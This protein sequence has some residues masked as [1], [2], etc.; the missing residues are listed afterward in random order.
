MVILTKYNPET[1]ALST[2]PKDIRI[3]TETCD[4]ISVQTEIQTYEIQ[5]GNSNYP[6][7]IYET[8]VVHNVGVRFTTINSATLAFLQ[9]AE[10][11][12]ESGLMK[13][14]TQ[15]SI[16]T[17]APYEIPAL[18]NVSGDGVVIDSESKRFTKVSSNPGINQYSITP[19]T[20]GTR[21]SMAK[22]V[23]AAATTAGTATI[24][25]TAAGS[26]A[27][28][29]GKAVVVNL[30]DTSINANASEIRSALESD[31]DISGYFD[32][33]GEDSEVILTRKVAADAESEAFSFALGTAEGATMGATTTI[34][35]EPDVPSKFVFN[36]ANKGQPITL[37]YDFYASGIE[38]YDIDENAINPVVQIEIIHE[39]MSRDKTKKYKN[40][41]KIS[42]AQLTG[43]ID[44]KL[45]RQHD[46]VTLTFTAIEPVGR[47]VVKNKKVEIPL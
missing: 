19:G 35:G 38:A 3:C 22:S 41:S 40:Y 25:I 12:I 10:L 32:I 44:I 7:G 5:N 13:E 47:K 15:T 31:P 36:A 23:T 18:G 27:L 39:T 4:E 2:D 20:T 24:T 33:G 28:A 37:S 34:P 43:N 46:P 1:G 30:S 8:G 16:P 6:A 26:P 17:E 14:L 45:A 21:Q 29:S 11:R 42:R 9:N